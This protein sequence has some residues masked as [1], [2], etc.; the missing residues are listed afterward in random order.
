[1]RPHRALVLLL[2]SFWALPAAAVAAEPA[3]LA[4]ARAL[5]NA[6]SYDEAIEAASI[7]RQQPQWAD[8]AALVLA[9]SQLERGRLRNDAADLASARD[10]L[11]AI[12]A[13]ALTPRDQLDLLIGFGQALYLGDEFGAAGDVFETA[14]GRASMLSPPDRLLLLEW[15]ATALDREAQSRPPDRRAGLFA[16]V[17]DRMTDDLR[18]DPG[19]RVANYWLVVAARGSGDIDRAWDTAIA[20]WVRAGLSPDRTALRGDIDQLVTTALIPERVRLRPAREHPEALNAL[21]AEWDQVKSDW[22]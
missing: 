18:Q 6:A 4:R 12:R 11:S 16:R 1:M 17:A 10:T 21:R 9:R 8:A 15:W 5:Y 7:A 13:A 19:S 22:K 14:L 3:A 2:L 20:A